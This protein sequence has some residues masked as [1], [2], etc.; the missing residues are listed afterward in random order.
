M[1]RNPYTKKIVPRRKR[2]IV[3]RKSFRGNAACTILINKEIDKL[4]LVNKIKAAIKEKADK[5]AENEKR[6]KDTEDFLTA[7]FNRYSTTITGF[8]SLNV[9]KGLLT[10]DIDKL[11]CVTVDSNGEISGCKITMPEVN[12]VEDVMNFPIEASVIK[13]R[14]MV[15]QIQIK[16]LGTTGITDSS[17]EGKAS[18]YEGKIYFR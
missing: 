4:K 10:L 5:A 1:N 18:F 17:P 3:I 6:E 15:V 13:T 12:T 14:L 9:K 7:L 16:E 11:G 2:C 8:K